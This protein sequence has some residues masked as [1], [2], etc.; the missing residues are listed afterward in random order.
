M[1][2]QDYNTNFTQA[3]AISPTSTGTSE[4]GSVIDTLDAAD[5]GM[6][7]D[8]TWLINIITAFSTGSSPTLQ[9]Q[10]QG[11][12]TDSTFTSGN[13][14]VYDTGTIAAATLI[15]GYMFA[16]KYP[17]GYTVRWL[18]M[19]QIVG[20]AAFTTGSYLSWLSNDQV[21]DNKYFPAGY[22]IKS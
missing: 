5:W 7:N 12:P 20:T 9:F 16:F 14:T 4:P 2:I 13:V 18:R 21:Q 11:N 3:G 6:G 8:W 15:A 22:T 10:L 17:R 1:P 19:V